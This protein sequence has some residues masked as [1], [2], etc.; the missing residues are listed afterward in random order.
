MSILKI[1]TK[2]GFVVRHDVLT[3]FSR[4]KSMS[5][6]RARA[7]VRSYKLKKISDPAVID[8]MCA[9]VS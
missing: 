9:G 1:K 4:M 3:I 2:S 5:N 6:T 7:R 8:V